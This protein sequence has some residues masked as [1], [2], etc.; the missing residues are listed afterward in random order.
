MTGKLHVLEGGKGSGRRGLSLHPDDYEDKIPASEFITPAADSKGHSA[1]L[2]THVPVGMAHEIDVH[3][4]SGSLPF[5]TRAEL[6]RW[7][8]Y[9]GLE[10]LAD[11]L[12]N[13]EVSNVRAQMNTLVAAARL[14]QDMMDF[15]VTVL[16]V[17]QTLKRLKEQGDR[18]QA[19][20]LLREIEE[21][22][23]KMDDEDWK[24]K[25]KR[26]LKEEMEAK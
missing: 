9:R 17:R 22:V 7:T 14:Q 20:K 19:R 18:K 23:D 1:K 4:A 15:E 21:H 13:K 12:R 24:E 25:Y 8:V 3:V 6:V 26:V 10:V 2:E 5:K 11:L 16:K